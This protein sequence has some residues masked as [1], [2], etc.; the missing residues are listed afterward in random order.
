MILLPIRRELD[1]S[2]FVSDFAALFTMA[3]AGYA[4]LLIS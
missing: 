4:F 3:F 2:N 1:M